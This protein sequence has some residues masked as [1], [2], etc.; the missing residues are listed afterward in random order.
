M[1]MLV[2]SALAKGWSVG[3]EGDVTETGF[4]YY[5]GYASI[6]NA[7]RQ[8][9]EERLANYKD[10]STERDHMLHIVGAGKDE[11]GRKWY[12]LKNSWGTWFSKY[13][14]YLFMD[15]NYFKLKTVIM[16]VNKAGLPQGLKEKLR[17]K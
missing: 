17:L 8:F 1:M 14:G 9:D 6:D 16:M 5:G 4:N 15:E 12:R 11:N 2:D 3:W 10:E 7:A 13:K